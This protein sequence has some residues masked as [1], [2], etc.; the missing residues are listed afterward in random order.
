MAGNSDKQPLFEYLLRLGDNSL[1]LGHRLSEW[2]GHGPELEEDIALT[3]IALDLIGQAR[4]LLSY[5][6]EVEGEGRSEDDLAY[7][8]DGLEYRNVLLVEQPN[9]DYAFTIAR[10]F[11]FDAF[12]YE[13]YARLTESQEEQLAAIAAKALKEVRYHRRHS[14]EW[15]I[16]LGDGTEL[17]HEKMQTAVNALWM[18]TGELFEMDAV[19]EAVVRAGIGADLEAIRPAWDRHVSAVLEEA[20]VAR[21]ETGWMQSGGKTGRHSEHLG[22]I[23]A[24][25]QFLQRAY[26]GATW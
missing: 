26:P 17:S 12:N 4:M 19:D 22:Y 3:N 13:L 24:D 11:F 16:R 5:A 18:Y 6:G 25:M 14:A 8:R 1:I 2:C 23:L 21:P 20:T 9:Q 15:L 10:Q 7:L